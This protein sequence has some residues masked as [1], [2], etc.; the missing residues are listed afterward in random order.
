M[1]FAP[2]EEYDEKYKKMQPSQLK[3]ALSDKIYEGIDKPS[4]CMT[5]KIARKP[6]AHHDKVTNK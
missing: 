5:C 6:R 1:N 4:Y 2:I 3:K